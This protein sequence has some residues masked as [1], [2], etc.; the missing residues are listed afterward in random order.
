MREAEI[1]DAPALARL[2]N[3]LEKESNF[4]LFE[5]DERNMSAQQ[6]EGMIRS[7]QS[8]ENST[9]W[10]AFDEGRVIGHVTCI[11]GRA[12]RNSHC[13]KVV[14]GVRKEQQGKGVAF[15]LLEKVKE[16]AVN[17]GIHRLELSVMVHNEPAFHVY[18]KAGFEVEGRLKHSLCVDGNWIDEHMMALIL[19]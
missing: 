1:K 6:A 2:M 3:E 8:Q 10:L 15:S 12:N 5:P 16:W 4:L 14:A 19:S 18:K 7:F 11:G 17:S 9:V 13:A